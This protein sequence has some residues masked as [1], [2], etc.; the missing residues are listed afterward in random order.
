LSFN[1]REAS[2]NILEDIFGKTFNNLALKNYF[3]AHELPASTK[4]FVTEV[5]NGVLRNLTY[6]DFC[7]TFYSNAGKMKPFIKNLLRISVYQLLYMDK[8][9]PYAVINEAV[10]ICRKRKFQN[11]SG[12]V[13]AVLRKFLTEAQ[14][15]S[16]PAPDTND[17]SLYLSTVYSIP[18]WIVKMWMNNYETGV[19]EEI[20]KT[21]RTRP[22]VTIAVNKAKTT[23]ATLTE[24]LLSASVKV[25]DTFHE[26]ALKIT[27]TGNIAELE[28][29]KSGCFHIMDISAMLAADMINCRAGDTVLDVC[30][31]PGGKSFY[32]A[33]NYGAKL[34]A[35]DIYPHKLE[36]ISKTAKRLGLEN[37][38]K[39]IERD[40]VAKNAAFTEKFD[41]VLVD[42]P[43]SGLGILR[44]K[45]DIKFNRTESDIDDLAKLQ[46]EILTNSADCVKAGSVLLYCTCT[47]SQKENR[48]VIDS[49]LAQHGGRFTFEAE[50][51]ILPCEYGSDGFYVAKLRRL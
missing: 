35:C 38:I 17:F 31:A 21:L 33:A 13:N 51:E 29:F 49:F 14:N 11:L 26:N 44:K 47:L 28:A 22:E 19:C 20:C 41:N 25:T 42:A 27:D 40:A 30:A 1:E 9:P 5:V 46:L 37:N 12:F 34:T 23:K 10:N 48:G 32:L 45:P 2:L 18:Q 6:I 36:L 43:C 3:K 4:K 39:V 15:G 7:I 24:K 8:I 50:R 16:L